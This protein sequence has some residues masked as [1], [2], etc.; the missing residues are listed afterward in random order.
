V[1]QIHL[2]CAGELFVETDSVDN[3]M[4][5]RAGLLLKLI[6]QRLANHKS[7]KAD[8]KK[9]SHF[10]LGWF[11]GKVS[12]VA[13]TAVLADHVRDE[14]EAIDANACLLQHPT[15][16]VD[17]KFLVIIDDLLTKAEGCYLH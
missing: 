16:G 11:S 4:T 12:C 9:Q 1:R 5:A 17:D 7:E 2:N 6:R 14:P 15:E 8:A 10:A 13:A 3:A